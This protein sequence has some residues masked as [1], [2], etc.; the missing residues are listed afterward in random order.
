MIFDGRHIWMAVGDGWLGGEKP[1]GLLSTANVQYKFTD[2]IY[3]SLI[4]DHVME[5]ESYDSTLR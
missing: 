5:L 3:S 2:S 4:P 1:I